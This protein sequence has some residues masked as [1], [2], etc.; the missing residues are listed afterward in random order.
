MKTRK[1]TPFAAALINITLTLAFFV[2]AVILLA[3]IMTKDDIL[4][5]VYKT[6]YIAIGGLSA[7]VLSFLNVKRVKV[8]PVVMF[9]VSAAVT[10]VFVLLPVF[11]VS[12]AQTGASVLL[13][14]AACTASSFVGTAVAGKI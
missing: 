10:S 5:A 8:K 3:Y 13:L 6:A 7:L 12:G 1:K 11:A 2:S 4:P 14:P 9:I